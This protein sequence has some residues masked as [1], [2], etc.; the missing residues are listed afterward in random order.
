MTKFS[1]KKKL[2]V[3][4]GTIALASALYGGKNAY[5][6]YIS[7]KEI[8]ALLDLRRTPILESDFTQDIRVNGRMIQTNP[9]AIASP[10]QIRNLP[11]VPTHRPIIS[12]SITLPL[13]NQESNLRDRLS[14]LE[15]L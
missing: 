12:D 7:N 8:D 11:S 13:Y 3:V 5:D 2:A 15:Q 10:N 6:D 4:A 1:K 14:Y 9:Y